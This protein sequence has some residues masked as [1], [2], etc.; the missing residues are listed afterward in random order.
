MLT[1]THTL[2]CLSAFFGLPL[3]IAG[4]TDSVVEDSAT[5][6]TKAG[7]EPAAIGTPL[8]SIEFTATAMAEQLVVAED[9]SVTHKEID[10]REAIQANDGLILVDFW[11]SWCGPCRTLAPELEKLAAENPGGITVLKVDSDQAKDLAA[12]FDV[13]YLP[14]MRV[15]KAGEQIARVDQA[16]TSTAIAA[17]L[18]L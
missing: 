4:C 2:L 17:Q 8:E 16:R 13:Q 3:L 1:R 14:D 9:G 15:F 10:F 5:A 11:A 7:A 6:E 18:G 12:E